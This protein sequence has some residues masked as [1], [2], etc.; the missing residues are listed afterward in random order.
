[1]ACKFCEGG[2]VSLF[3]SISDRLSYKGDFYPGTDVYIVENRL[4]IDVI[5]DTYEPCYIEERFEIKFCPMC[6]RKLTDK[7]ESEVK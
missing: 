7:T 6:G 2:G 4:H 1:M 5:P 3:C